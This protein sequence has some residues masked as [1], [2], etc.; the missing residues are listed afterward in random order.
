[1]EVVKEAEIFY[2]KENIKLF[3]IYTINSDPRVIETAELLRK[4]LGDDIEIFVGQI[5]DITQARLLVEKAKVDALIF[6]HGGGRQCTSATNGMAIS[7][8]EEIYSIIKDEFFNDTSLIVEGGVGKSVGALIILGVDCILYNQQLVKGT[9]EIGGLFLQHL[10]GTFVQPYHG[11]ASAPTMIIEA[12]NPNM[13]D[14]RIDCSGRTKIPEG[15]PGYSK[16]SEKANSMTYWVEEFK[17]QA[18]RTLADLG[19]ENMSELRTF[20]QTT[21]LDMLRIVSPE[22]AKTASAYGTAPFEY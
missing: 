19:V 3:R 15:K 13:H 4:K 6:G 21:D 9:L 12:A 16:Y 8:V 22:A 10:N 11:S 1:E 14:Q 7:T 5:S 17:H 18:A 20:L 2:K